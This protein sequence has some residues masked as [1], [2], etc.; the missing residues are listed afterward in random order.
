MN[1]LDRVMVSAAG[2][3]QVYP[4]DPALPEL[5]NAINAEMRRSHARLWIPFASLQTCAKL[6]LSDGVKVTI[7]SIFWHC[8]AAGHQ[9]GPVATI[10]LTKE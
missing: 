10:N 6:I 3:E 4:D 9:A 7:G 2:L 8:V 1:A 5:Q